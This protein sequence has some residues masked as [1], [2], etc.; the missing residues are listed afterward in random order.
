MHVIAAKAVA[1]YEAATEEFADY[2]RR[3]VLNARILA[4]TLMEKGFRLISG[5]TDNHLI[6]MDVS[7]KQITG[8]QAQEVLEK[9]GITVNK[10]SIPFDPLPPGKA[11]GIR[12]GTPSC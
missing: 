9:A 4:E 2:Q 8:A 1:L 10:N 12:I 7:D 11:S 6:L 3:T 5:G